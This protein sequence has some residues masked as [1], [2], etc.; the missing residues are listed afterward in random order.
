MFSYTAEN[1]QLLE[2]VKE[3][4]ERVVEQ[5]NVSYFQ[6][7]KFDVLIIFIGWLCSHTYVS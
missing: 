2:K 6:I 4:E 5:K 7:N 1:S 3:L